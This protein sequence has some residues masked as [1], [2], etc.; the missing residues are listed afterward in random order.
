MESQRKSRFIVP[1]EERDRPPVIRQKLPIPSGAQDQQSEELNKLLP[2]HPRIKK[3]DQGINTNNPDHPHF[4]LRRRSVSHQPIPS[5]LVP[6]PSGKNNPYQSTHLPWISPVSLHPDQPIRM[7]SIPPNHPK[8][9]SPLPTQSKGSFPH[10]PPKPTPIGQSAGKQSPPSLRIFT[11][12]S[13]SIH[14]SIFTAFLIC[15]LAIII[16]RF[17]RI[18]STT[19]QV[20]PSPNS[21]LTDTVANLRTEKIKE[22]WFNQSITPLPKSATIPHSPIVENYIKTM[23]HL[24]LN[25]RQQGLWI[26]S[27]N[28]VLGSYQGTTPFPAASLTKLLTTLVALDRWGPK[29]QF[30]TIVKI[31][32]T[33]RGDRVEGDLIIEGKG[34]PF[35]VWESAIALGNLLNQRNIR[36]FTGNLLITGNFAMNFEQ[37]PLKSGLLLKQGLNVALWNKVPLQQYQTL[38]STTPKP[39]VT[40]LGKVLVHPAPMATTIKPFVVLPSLPLVQLL[41][42]QNLYSNNGMAE[43]IAQSLGGASTIQQRTL[44]L[45]ALPSHEVQVMNGSGLGQENRLSP[46][47]ACTVLGALKTQLQHAGLN[48]GDIVETMGKDEG[49]LALRRLPLL[50]MAK[51]GTLGTVSTL[52]GITVNSTGEPICIAISNQGTDVKVLRL[53]QDDLVT[54]VHRS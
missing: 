2:G 43:I 15:G 51:T 36:Q 29:H 50:T 37:D 13:Q 25:P 19:W 26:Q 44:E 5:Y 30:A 9:L 47:A 32:G 16:G 46:R 24:Q 17:L 41:R 8:P 35:F 34:D 45:T 18:N 27:R 52:A 3:P 31:T 48:L 12:L 21:G 4:P 7:G 33:Q 28:Q 1:R 42:R 22:P 54:A 38:P 11:S 10:C 49:L 39:S 6:P 14:K 23:N 40:I 53:E 20:Q